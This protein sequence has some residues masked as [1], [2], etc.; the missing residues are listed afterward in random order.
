MACPPP[1]RWIPRPRRWYRWG[2]WRRPGHRGLPGNGAAPGRWRRARADDELPRRAAGGRPCGGAR[3]V[4]RST[5]SG[6]PYSPRRGPVPC[7]HVPELNCVATSADISGAMRAP[8]RVS[9]AEEVAGGVGDV[10]GG[11]PGGFHEFGGGAGAG[12]AADRQVGDL[13]RVAGVAERLEDRFADAAF[14]VVVFGDDEPAAGCGRGLEE[15]G[16][17][18]RLDRVQVEDAG[19]D[20]VAA[21]FVRGGQAVVQGDPGADQRDLVV[22]AG[23]DEFGAALTNWNDGWPNR[24]SLTPSHSKTTGLAQ[25]FL[26]LHL[27]QVEVEVRLDT[28]TRSN[29]VVLASRAG[30]SARPGRNSASANSSSKIASL[31][32]PGRSGSRRSRAIPASHHTA[33]RRSAPAPRSGCRVAGA[34]AHQ[35]DQTASA[36]S[37]QLIGPGGVQVGG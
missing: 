4:I 27:P 37:A 28:A 22:G 17:V 10:G 24:P 8:R 31:T 26:A 30:D 2:R 14:G 18:D 5:C 23:P 36:G 32:V 29:A 11:D 7:S 35:H 19:A 34:A 25:P 12:Q 33:A 3:P 21:K 1:G 6:R 9:G 13:G 20:P 16:G 15:G